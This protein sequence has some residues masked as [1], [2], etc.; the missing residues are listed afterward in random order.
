MIILEFLE[1]ALLNVARFFVWIVTA[2]DCKHCK[3]YQR[4]ILFGYV[5]E[6]RTSEMSDCLGS[7]TRKYFEKESEDTSCN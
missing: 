2:R 1:S 7:V 5:C 6:K 3:H 4:G